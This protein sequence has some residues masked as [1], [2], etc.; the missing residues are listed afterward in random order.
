DQM[1]QRTLQDRPQLVKSIANLIRKGMSD[2]S[3]IG[4]LTQD[5]YLHT[6][7]AWSVI[8]EAEQQIRA[9][10]EELEPRDD[11]LL[12]PPSSPKAR[13][14]LRQ[15]Q[16]SQRKRFGKWALFDKFEKA[17][18]GISG[19]VILKLRQ[20]NDIGARRQ[21][22]L[23]HKIPHAAEIAGKFL[24]QAVENLLK[25]QPAAKEVAAVNKY[26]RWGGEGRYLVAY[27]NDEFDYIMKTYHSDRMIGGAPA[28]KIVQVEW[29]EEG[30]QAAKQR[31]E[32]IA[33]PTLVIDATNGTT[34][35][36]AYLLD[37]VGQRKTDIAII[38]NKITPLLEY[39]KT[40]VRAGKVEEAKRLIDEYKRTAIL[41][42]R[43]GVVDK[44]FG[45]TL[46]NYGFDEKS[47]R[48][49]VFDFGDLSTGYQPAY[50]FVDYIDGATNTYI[51]RGLRSEVDDEVANYFQAN[52]FKESDFY[53]Q[54]GKLLFGVDFTDENAT[55]FRMIFPFSEAEVREM[56]LNHSIKQKG[57]SSHRAEL[58][59]SRID[60]EHISTKALRESSRTGFLS[61]ARAKLP[62]ASVKPGTVEP[63]AMESL[64]AELPSA[65][66]PMTALASKPAASM[67][68][69]PSARAELRT[70]RPP[71]RVD[72][73][74]E[75]RQEQGR[76]VRKGVESPTRGIQQATQVDQKKRL[77]IPLEKLSDDAFRKKF[78]ETLERRGKDPHLEF[79]ILASGFELRAE[80]KALK[81][82]N[83]RNV[84]VEFNVQLFGP[85][86]FGQTVKSEAALMNNM[87][88]MM[89]HEVGLSPREFSTRV[90]VIGD[91]KIFQKVQ[92][93]DT[94]K[95][96]AQPEVMEA[97][98][99]LFE[100]DG[101][102]DWFRI[103]GSN[104]VLDVTRSILNLLNQAVRSQLK[105]E[106]AA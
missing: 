37:G 11:G 58:R 79:V 82:L 40:L 93:R 99:L 44:D 85:E 68:K 38:Q 29:I 41:M 25:Q 48:V 1:Q 46:A 15:S 106:M 28:K 35:E 45:G 98:L 63:Q 19:D 24:N 21:I 27:A 61:D 76:G 33:A 8:N 18:A 91:E 73:E 43:R 6:G 102:L 47:G 72:S 67:S 60:P 17:L 55:Q 65:T 23:D 105:I 30:F 9:E 83:Q 97:A 10:Q 56:F 84:F 57:K 101:A 81:L 75:V 87:I 42:F 51:E 64:R 74:A 34:N 77:I 69:L 4:F 71:N 52:P 31:L 103:A 80:R 92:R 89:R 26:L 86:R 95:L 96:L 49:Y 7:Q 39:L 20:A 32:G 54:S 13:A 62:T 59:H 66:P 90:I 88:N 3:L 104:G 2:N 53:N 5:L 70:V 100:L 78:L 36:F 22:L 14:E 16:Q 94:P 50:E 12:M